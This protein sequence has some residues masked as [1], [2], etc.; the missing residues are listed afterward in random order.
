MFKV[1]KLDSLYEYVKE[2]LE[3]EHRHTHALY[4]GLCDRI[5]DHAENDRKYTED[6]LRFMQIMNDHMLDRIRLLEEQ[7]DLLTKKLEES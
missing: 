3:E 5:D 4:D 2:R 7:V 1:S 6:L